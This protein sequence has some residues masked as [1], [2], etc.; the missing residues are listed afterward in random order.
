MSRRLN[1]KPSP[2]DER[3]YA[4]KVR[5]PI[6]L[7]A[8]AEVILNRLPKV[9]D[10][11]DLG[12]CVAH[13]LA[14]TTYVNLKATRRRAFILSR[15]AAYYEARALEGTIEEDA[16]CYIRDAVKAMAKTGAG[17]EPTWPYRIPLFTRKPPAK[18]YASAKLCKVTR[19]ERVPHKLQNIKEA[20]ARGYPV[21]FGFEVP[22]S[23]MSDAVA[24]TGKMPMPRKGEAVEGGHC[25]VAVGY[26]DARKA[27]RCRNSWGQGWGAKGD[28]WMP[29]KFIADPKWCNDF[30]CFWN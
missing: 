9:L 23:F 27:V 3:D 16:G 7:P 14:A 4:F 12:S 26:D 28:F 30:W 15:L 24:K 25:V 19:Y 2:P 20:L 13:G 6:K 21:V 29:Y 17:R 11:G 1:W 8:K 22:E 5:K 18:F 10:Q